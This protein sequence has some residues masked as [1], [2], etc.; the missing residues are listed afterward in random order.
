MIDL[1]IEGGAERVTEGSET[2]RTRHVP[3]ARYTEV[4]IEW[5]HGR[6]KRDTGN[7]AGSLQQHRVVVCSYLGPD[8]WGCEF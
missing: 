1:V 2:M 7:R 5:Q 8:E 4:Q 6:E 3:N